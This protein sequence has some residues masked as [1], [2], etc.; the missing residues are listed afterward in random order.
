MKPAHSFLMGV[1]LS[2]RFIKV[3][4]DADDGKN[5]TMKLSG[6]VTERSVVFGSDDGLP[7]A[8]SR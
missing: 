8:R 7:S 6:S 3:A 1:K 4:I 5:V 2:A